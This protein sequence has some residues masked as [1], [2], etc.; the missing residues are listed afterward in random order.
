MQFCS[1]IGISIA[2]VLMVSSAH[3][4]DGRIEI[5][6]ACATTTGC[7]PGDDPGFPITLDD[8]SGRNFILTS[9][10]RVPSDTD[11]FVLSA[12]VNL[13]FDLNGF[14]VFGPATC[15]QSNCPL[16]TGAGF[17]GA[18]SVA[19][20]RHTTV[21]NG[22]VRGFAGDCV[23]LLLAARVAELE[24]TE[25]GGS[26]ISVSS[27]SLVTHNRVSQTGKEGIR[28]S[29]LAD[30]PA[31]AHNVVSDAGL[32]GGGE[33]AVSGGEPTAGNRCDDGSCSSRGQRRYYLSENE[34]I[35]TGALAVC[36]PGFHLASFSELAQ[37]SNLEYDTRRGLTYDGSDTGP[38]WAANG[39]VSGGDTCSGW[40]KGDLNSTGSTV[41]VIG[42]HEGGAS[43]QWGG[44]PATCDQPYRVWCVED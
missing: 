43:T 10:I 23:Q 18:L 4:A 41:W 26:G 13:T 29:G 31:F 36:D 5:N 15:T 2:I 19:F 33:P 38:P 35:G 16:G 6:Q 9:D 28:M 3:A 30:P 34:T 8:T 20:A 25:C 17:R 44:A 27:T 39:W 22:T 40:T 1:R 21:R 32:G 24:V 11:G 42:I 14:T 37:T 12:T 7:F